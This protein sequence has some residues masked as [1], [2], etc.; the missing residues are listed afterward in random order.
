[1][2]EKLVM[3]KIRSFAVILTRLWAKSARKLSNLY[4]NNKQ[5]LET[6]F[7]MPNIQ[8]SVTSTS[9]LSVGRPPKAFAECTERSKNRKIK[10]LLKSY[11][12]P[13]IFYAA[14]SKLKK[15]GKRNTAMLLKESLITPTRSTKIKKAYLSSLS[16]GITPYTA[17]EALAFILDNNLTKQQ[18]INIRKSAKLRNAKIYPSYE[19]NLDSKKFLLFHDYK[20]SE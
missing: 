20:Y 18:Y 10:G 1:M 9:C 11:S 16:I 2:Y 13:E 5:W 7:I 15:S 3:E 14:Q 4:K 8:P 17:D 19:K 12:S 6:E